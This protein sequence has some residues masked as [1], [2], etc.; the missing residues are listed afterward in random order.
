MLGRF[1]FAARCSAAYPATR[2]RKARNR[3]LA[4]SSADTIYGGAGNDTIDGGDGIDKLFADA[5]NDTLTGGTGADKL[6]G[7]AG[8]DTFNAK[9]STVDTIDGGDGSDK[10]RVDGAPTADLVRRIESFF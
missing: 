4:S 6:Y 5:G 2:W 8:T 3:A 7:S 10:A 9:D 1:L